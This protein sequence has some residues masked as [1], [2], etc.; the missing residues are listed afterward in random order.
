MNG[1]KA[2]REMKQDPDSMT[3]KGG[4]MDDDDI[5]EDTGE[6]NMPRKDEKSDIWLTRIPKW[7]Y[8]S[9]AKEGD[10]DEIE[11]GKIAVFL[12]EK[13]GRVSKERPMHVFL[14]DHWYEEAKL[15]RAFEVAPAPHVDPNT[16]IFTEK[17]LP[18]FKP[19]T[20]GRSRVEH[21]SNYNK[22]NHGKVQ[23]RGKWRKP[24]PKHT[25]L[26]GTTTRE[27]SAR[28]LQTPEYRNFMAN[29]NKIAFEG[30]NKSTILLDSNINY[31]HNPSA[32]KIFEGFIRTGAATKKQ[33]NKAARIPKN[34]LIDMLHRLFD[35]YAYYPMRVLK[36]QTRQP[37]AYLKE[38]LLEIADLVKTGPFASCWKRHNEYNKTTITQVQDKPPEVEGDDAALDDDDDNMEMEDVV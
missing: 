7:L 5:Y 9:L 19:M 2:E 35:Q 29:R 34:E 3:P 6:L 4:F 32:G 31:T 36:L 28:P 1:V 33:E 23:K 21:P 10:D 24:V 27:Y 15:P 30:K 26:I 25:A 38:T 14:N 12:D 18:G 17:D 37:E 22:D 8:E 16:Y 11:I 20:Y 13:T